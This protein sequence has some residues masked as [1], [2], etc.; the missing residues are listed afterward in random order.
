MYSTNV[1]DPNNN[2]KYKNIEEIL[3]KS[4]PKKKKKIKKIKKE[5]TFKSFQKRKKKKKKHIPI[6]LVTTPKIFAGD[7]EDRRRFF[8]FVLF[9]SS[10]PR[11]C[12]VLFV[13]SS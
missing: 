1:F 10:V 4:K 5:D 9:S 12:V 11:C 3:P 13:A 7:G 6:A 8:L 2:K